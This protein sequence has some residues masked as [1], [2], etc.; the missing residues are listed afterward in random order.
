[1]PCGSGRA[2]PAADAVAL[3]AGAVVFVGPLFIAAA[4]WRLARTAGAPPSIFCAICHAAAASRV[5]H[6][7]MADFDDSS[8]WRISAYERMRAETGSSG[9]AVLGRQTT[10]PTTKTSGSSAICSAP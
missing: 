5:Y 3:G 7:A 6:R 10:L 1:M 4:L 9:Y 2:V 8:L